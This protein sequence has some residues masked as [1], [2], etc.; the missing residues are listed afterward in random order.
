M[1]TWPKY[2]PERHRRV[3]DPRVM[4]CFCSEEF[5]CSEDQPCPCCET[6][7]ADAAEAALERV[8]KLRDQWDK[9]ESEHVTS[10]GQHLPCSVA[11]MSGMLTRALDGGAE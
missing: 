7:R 6:A 2:N 10:F 1:S 9:D 5:Y 8:R 4:D 11:S 3:H